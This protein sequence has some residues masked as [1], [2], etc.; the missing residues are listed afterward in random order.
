MNLAAPDSFSI[1]ASRAG[2]QEHGSLRAWVTG[3]GGLIG[4]WLLRTAA[5]AAP[6]CEVIPLDRKQLDL[7]DFQAVRRR[8]SQ[9]HPD[10]VIHCAALSRSPDCEADP[11]L[12]RLVNVEVVRRLA[13]LL[14][15]KRFVFF[16]TDLVFDGR[17]GN[18]DEDA[19]PN[20]L[21]IY[22]ETK[23][24]AE[25]AVL[26]NREHIVIRTSLNGGASPT[27]DRGF[28][29]QMRLAWKQG[30]TTR[31]FTDEFRS[32]IWAGLTARAAWEIARRGEGG[33]YHVAGGERVSRWGIG[34]ALAA[35]WEQLKPR[36]EPAS[37]KEYQGA[38]RAP[39]TSLN[40]E[41]AQ[42]VLS[43][44]LPRFTEWLNAQPPGSF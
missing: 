27:G 13:D 41:K 33:I 23:V 6:G 39:D 34:K 44:P 4:S 42:R 28:N 25:R 16:S 12:A 30:R 32:P 29:E 21:S 35:R 1:G 5:E 24:E 26:P 17:R 36:I 37:L 38:P 8:F 15:G 2:C 9:D 40:C 18:Y 14:A 3:A 43:F 20:P 31:L 11:Q 19:Q 10:L 7:T 22:A